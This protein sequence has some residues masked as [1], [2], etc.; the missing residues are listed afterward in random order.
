[1]S[2]TMV[3]A[4]VGDAGGGYRGSPRLRAAAHASGS[5]N[6]D[7]DF[8]N[9]QHF[10]EEYNEEEYE[11]DEDEDEVV[12]NGHWVQFE[13]PCWFE[14]DIPLIPYQCVQRHFQYNYWLNTFGDCDLPKSISFLPSSLL[15]DKM[16]WLPAPRGHQLTAEVRGS[17]LTILCPP[18][19]SSLPA[20]R[21]CL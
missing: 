4:G 21:P 5:H 2:C 18:S 13:E 15:E 19:S 10:F 1:M 7:L 3:S 14:D 20:P 17:P 11:E 8:G 16:G 12:G 9:H 6:P